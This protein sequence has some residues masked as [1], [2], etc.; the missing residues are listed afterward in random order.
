MELKEFLMLS[1]VKMG[2]IWTK[3]FVM[4][5]EIDDKSKHVII[6]ATLES[7]RGNVPV[8]KPLRGC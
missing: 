5:Y 1:N 6:S 4:R 8:L 3:R 2:Q 7:A